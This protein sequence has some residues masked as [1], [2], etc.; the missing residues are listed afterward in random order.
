MGKGYSSDDNRSMQL[1]DNNDRYYSSRGIDRDDLDWEDDNDDNDDNDETGEHM[2]FEIGNEIINSRH[3]TGVEVKKCEVDVKI[4]KIKNDEYDRR[5]YYS[6]RG[7]E[8]IH[9]AVIYVNINA[10]INMSDRKN[11]PKFII[12]TCVSD[13]DGEEANVYKARFSS[14]INHSEDFPDLSS[15]NRRIEPRT[16]SIMTIE[17]VNVDEM[18]ENIKSDMQKTV[19]QFVIAYVNQT[20]LDQ[21]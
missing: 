12:K 2:L 15:L 10:S 17:D 9:R 18:I 8:Y 1:N 6:A 11:G 21:R 13:S 5:D 14:R 19:N 16:R 20:M 7:Q 3:I 4:K